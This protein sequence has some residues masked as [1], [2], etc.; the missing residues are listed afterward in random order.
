MIT[1]KN[2]YNFE[3]LTFQNNK[4]KIKFKICYKYHV[5]N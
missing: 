1:L 3:N 4:F 5:K 2:K